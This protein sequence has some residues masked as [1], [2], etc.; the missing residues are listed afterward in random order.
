MVDVVRRAD[1]C[2]RRARGPKPP[3]EFLL[4]AQELVLMVASRSRYPFVLHGS[5][6]RQAW[7]PA[8]RAGS[9]DAHFDLDF[10]VLCPA[11]EHHD[12]RVLNEFAADVED[13]WVKYY[14][15]LLHPDGHPMV[16]GSW[17]YDEHL[18][19]VSS[20][21]MLHGLYLM[22]LR[23]GGEAVCDAMMF[24]FQDHMTTTLCTVPLRFLESSCVV[25]ML[26]LSSQVMRMEAT[27]YGR[28]GS[29]GLPAL[30]V[31]INR[32]AA[33]SAARQLTLFL[34]VSRFAPGLL[35]AEPRGDLV[36]NPELQ[37][38]SRAG[39]LFWGVVCL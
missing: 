26:P 31:D 34:V 32:G 19:V 6:A 39:D 3:H 9:K 2:G 12:A 23:L 10:L 29:D 13:A 20:L 22:T 16:A 21:C 4:A 5:A 37:V 27:A 7:Y 25:S 36:L 38:G 28:P 33:T 17:H 8:C 24:P 11:A 30:A 14:S 15:T 35:F 18:R 1:L